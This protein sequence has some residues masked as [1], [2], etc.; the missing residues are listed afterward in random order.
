MN[1]DFEYKRIFE[2]V[3]ENLYLLVNHDKSVMYILINQ[4]KFYNTW[5]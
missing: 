5:S 2:S 3:F 4:D 1:N